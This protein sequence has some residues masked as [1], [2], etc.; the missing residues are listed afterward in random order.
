MRVLKDAYDDITGQ[1]TP[2]GQTLLPPCSGPRHMVFHPTATFAFVLNE[3]NNT[4]STLPYD[5][6]TG[7]LAAP[8][9]TISALVEQPDKRSD[10]GGA[11]EVVI[12]ADGSRVYCTVRLGRDFDPMEAAPAAAFGV[13]YN[14]VATFAVAEGGGGLELL[15]NVSCGGSMP[16][17]S[18]LHT[19]SAPQLAFKRRVY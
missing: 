11:A 2:H 17:V 9:A 5:S 10:R 4:I 18:Q 7:T 14:I 12:S 16:W 6:A 1:L 3:L 19:Q 15:G 13:E 8:I